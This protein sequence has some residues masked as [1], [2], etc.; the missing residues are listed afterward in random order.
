MKSARKRER[1]FATLEI[2]KEDIVNDDQS[3]YYNIE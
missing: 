3:I 2:S 1:E